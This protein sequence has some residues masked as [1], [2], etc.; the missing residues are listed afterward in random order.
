MSKDYG[1]F[2][3][4]LDGAAIGRPITR[5]GISFFPVYLMENGL[6]EI[7]TGPTAERVID[8]LGDASVG[9]LT[10]TNPGEAPL[11]LVE[12]EQFVGGKQNR[13]INVSVLVAAGATVRIP[14]TCLEQGRW[15]RRRDF[16]PAPTHTPRRVRRTLRDAV[17]AQAGTPYARR[18]AQSE[19]WGSIE[20]ELDQMGTSSP[21]AAIVDTDEVFRRDQGRGAAVEELVR[22]GPLPGQCGFVVAHG[23]RIVGAEIFGAPELLKPHWAA[24]VRSY[25]L[26][27]PT[28]RGW[29]SPER[30][31]RALRGISRAESKRSAGLGL[32]QERHYTSEKGAG[33]ALTL[34]G[35]AVHISVLS[36]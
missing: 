33:Q 25:L 32:G 2:F 12:G 8:E 30:V 21:T 22:L 11:L 4:N 13:T 9:D 36:R 35:A 29:P 23:P 14:V 28:A 19:V 7:A 24:L 20:G 6:P 26:E 31:L 3:P 18:G 1:H 17:A 15:G 5:A 27:E 34:E 10:L 16:R